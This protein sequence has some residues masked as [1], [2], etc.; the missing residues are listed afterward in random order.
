MMQFEKLGISRDR[1]RLEGFSPRDQL[2]RSYQKIDIALDTFPYPGGTTTAESLWMGVPVL[3]IRGDDF[4]SRIGASMLH[5][6]GNDDWIAIDQAHYVEL[7]IK[8]AKDLKYLGDLREQLRPKVKNSSLFNGRTFAK[9]FQDNI[10]AMW[11][12]LENEVN[13]RT[14]GLDD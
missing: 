5:E 7:A 14:S 4:L 9:Q 11:R 12:T 13:L 8:F 10:K 1:L 3:T 6:A 2:L